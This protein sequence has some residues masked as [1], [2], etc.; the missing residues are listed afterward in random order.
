MTTSELCSSFFWHRMKA[1]APQHFKASEGATRN[2]SDPSLVIRE[3]WLAGPAGEVVARTVDADASPLRHSCQLTLYRCGSEEAA[4][5]QP[6]RGFFA[7]VAHALRAASRFIYL[8]GWMF[9]PTIRLLR[10]TEDGTTLGQL[11]ADKASQ[12][13]RVCVLVWCPHAPT[14]PAATQYKDAAAFFEKTQVHFQLSFGSSVVYSHHQ[15]IVVCD[16]GSLV[17]SRPVVAFVGGLDLAAGRWDTRAHRLF[18]PSDVGPFA[19]DHY[20]GERDSSN[21]AA[22][23]G[24]P[25][26]PWQDIHARVLGPVCE[27][28]LRLFEARWRMELAA[29]FSTSLYPRTTGEFSFAAVDDGGWSVQRLVSYPRCVPQ[30]QTAYVHQIQAAQDFIYIEN[31]F[32]IGGLGPN[33]NCVP[34][35]LAHRVAANIRG[36]NQSFHVVVVLPLHPEGSLDVAKGGYKAKCAGNIVGLQLRTIE[37]MLEIIREAL[38]E[39]QRRF[40]EWTQYLSFFSLAQREPELDGALVGGGAGPDYGAAG[41]TKGALLACTRR[42]MVYVHRL[43]ECL[44]AQVRLTRAKASSCAL[45]LAAASWAAPTSTSGRSA[46]SATAR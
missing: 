11:L 30:I 16:Q 1:S 25:R 28:L 9:S 26:Q 45:T 46:A 23:P 10:A 34:T 4:P 33:S 31:Q 24:W 44:A 20:N 35:E 27:D 2:A 42:Y 22:V 38:E 40:A 37:A 29:S 21:E 41:E 7:D 32:F 17:G 18:V 43:G 39:R 15:K 13:V 36:G 12:G 6:E 5:G 19:S 14:D 8:A 3:R